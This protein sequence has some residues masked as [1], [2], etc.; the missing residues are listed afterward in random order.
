MQFPISLTTNLK[1]TVPTQS[2][3]QLAQLPDSYCT[4]RNWRQLVG[5]EKWRIECL[6]VSLT[7]RLFRTYQG[8]ICSYFA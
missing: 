7:E 4:A 8:D 2:S 3:R 5:A 6:Y 1:F